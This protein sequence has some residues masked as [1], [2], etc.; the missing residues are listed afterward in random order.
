[1][2][3]KESIP[4][5]YAAEF[6][7]QLRKSLVAQMVADTRYQ[8]TIANAGDRVKILEVGPI[9]VRSYTRNSTTDITVQTLDDA[10]QYLNIDQADYFAFG[11]DDVD[12][13]QALPGYMNEAMANAAYAQAQSADEYVLGLYAQAGVSIST[14][15]TVYNKNVLNVLGEIGAK[16]DNQGIMPGARFAIVPPGF[17]WKLVKALQLHQ[18]PNESVFM[19]GQG[20]ITTV[21]GFRIYM[22]HNL[23]GFTDGSTDETIQALF[24]SRG[25]IAFAGQVSSIERYRPEGEFK[26]AVKGLYVYGAKVVRPNQLAVVPMS[27][28]NEISGDT[29]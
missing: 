26:D 12:A 10:A 9:T 7:T 28:A 20:Y 13:A 15:T 1:M 4:I 5:R 18:M 2:A 23:S 6:L 3:L 19:Q 25:S 29:T 8:G 27:L 21:N 22:S 24:G 14:T 16:L 11:V 17:A